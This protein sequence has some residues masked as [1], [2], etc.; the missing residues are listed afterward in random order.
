[1]DE[2]TSALDLITQPQIIEL[3]RKLQAEKGLSYLFISHDLAVV[4]SITDRVLVMRAGKIV[5]E[6]ATEDVFRSPKHPYT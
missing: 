4:R 3:L 5:E 1:M 6:G 2:P